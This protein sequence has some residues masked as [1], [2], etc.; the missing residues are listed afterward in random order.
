[1]QTL[2]DQTDDNLGGGNF[3]AGI[4][5]CRKPDPGSGSMEKA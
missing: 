5:D 4:P 2:K 1:M 3:F